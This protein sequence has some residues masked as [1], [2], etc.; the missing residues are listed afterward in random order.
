MARK[1]SKG[2]IKAF[3]RLPWNEFQGQSQRKDSKDGGAAVGRPTRLSMIS[4]VFALDCIPRQ[5]R[6]YKAPN[7]LIR[8]LRAL[9]PYEAPNGLI[10]LLWALGPYEAL[11]GLIRLLGAL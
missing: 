9:G 10:R 11:N 8:L 1:A 5:L 4:L 3:K 7:G 6:P 2:L